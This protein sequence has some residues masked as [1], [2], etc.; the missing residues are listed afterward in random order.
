MKSSF[1]F[2]SIPNDMQY[3]MR[4]LYFSKRKSTLRSVQIERMVKPSAPLTIIKRTS[5]LS[6]SNE[7]QFTIRE[8]YSTERKNI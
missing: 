7:M 8:P 2:P 3:A 5:F 6:L 1:F 4:K